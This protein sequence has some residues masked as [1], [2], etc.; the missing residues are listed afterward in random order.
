MVALFRNMRSAVAVGALAAGALIGT[1]ASAADDI[2]VRFSW[3]MK[4]EYAPMYMTQA[5]GYFK[6]ANLNVRMGEGAGSQAA[7]GAL[8]QGQEDVVIMPG[9]F[10]LPAINQGMPVRIIALY[11][12]RV[13]AVLISHPDN[14]IV[15][16]ADLEG[17]RVAHAVGETGTSFLGVVCA[18]SNIDCDKIDLVTMASGAR[19]PS[20]LQRQVDAVS[21]YTT[22]DLPII[23][24]D[25]GKS[26]PVFNL[27]DHG[28]AVP[29]I[30]VV[31]SEAL[32]AEKGDALSRFLAAL[33]KGIRDSKADP[34]A[35]AKALLAEWPESPSEEAVV[36]QVEA[37]VA[38]IP[39]REG[40]PF[41]WIA[42]EDMQAAVEV[43]STDESFGD[44]RPVEQY[45][46]N[47]LFGGDS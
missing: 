21:V 25:V 11:H 19:I 12:P 18:A 5:Q 40:H 45:Y 34:E 30:S 3:K 29:G 39:E 8:L 4:G 24:R 33:D 22:N 6:D 15:D 37:T 31:T 44:P 7:L 43:L 42:K 38:A 35:A 17:K 32:I 41:G 36:A 14:P 1:S 20:F 28:L 27:A 2:N 23:E 13:P 16:P 47:Q 46:T 9:I 10:A 26:F